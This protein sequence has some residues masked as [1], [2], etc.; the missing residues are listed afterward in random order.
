MPFPSERDL[1]LAVTGTYC[2]RVRT[3]HITSL[4]L[5]V[6][7]CGHELAAYRR[8]HHWSRWWSHWAHSQSAHIIEGLPVP[9]HLCSHLP[10]RRL[11]PTDE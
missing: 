5:L 1:K 4:S 9:H 7:S 11:L 2:R 10:L 8:P 6:H 3:V